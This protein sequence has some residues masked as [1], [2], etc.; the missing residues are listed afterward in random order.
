MSPIGDVPVSHALLKS[1]VTCQFLHV[2]KVVKVISSI[3]GFQS[4]KVKGKSLKTCHAREYEMR[5]INKCE[6]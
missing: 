3:N 4:K 6:I 2:T 5:V 1:L